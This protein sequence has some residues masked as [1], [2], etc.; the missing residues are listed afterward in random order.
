M[1]HIQT[2]G[3]HAC[4]F[5]GE[6][7]SDCMFGWFQIC[8]FSLHL[9]AG[10]YTLSRIYIPAGNNFVR[11]YLELTEMLH[12]YQINWLR[13]TTLQIGLAKQPLVA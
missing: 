6:C 3:K 1:I 4:W 8:I 2:L 5:V 12:K 7:T 13:L 11:K 10:I 9:R